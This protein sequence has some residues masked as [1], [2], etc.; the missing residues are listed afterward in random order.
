MIEEKSESKEKILK[1]TF[2]IEITHQG[3]RYLK[4]K[5]TVRKV[6]KIIAEIIPGE[7]KTI[8]KI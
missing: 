3:K 4:E 7:L 2:G 6:V 5:N 8:L 1:E